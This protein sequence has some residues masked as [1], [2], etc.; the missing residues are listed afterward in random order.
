MQFPLVSI[1]IPSYNRAHLIGETLDSVLAQTYTNWEC[2]VVD[3]GSTD[4]TLEVLAGYCKKDARFQY[5][6]RPKNRTKG[7]NACRNYG[8]ELSKGKYIQLLDSDDILEVFCL[9]ERVNLILKEKS[10]NLLIRDT[11]NLID[12]Q[13]CIHSINK[14]PKFKTNEAYLRMF[15]SYDI[16]WQ[17]M[18]AFY[19]RDLFRTSHFDEALGRFQDV[20]FNIYVLSEFQDLKIKRDYKIDSYYR[21]DETKIHKNNFIKI[22]LNSLLLF[23]FIHKKLLKNRDYR[24]DLRKFNYK[25]A[26]EFVIPYFNQNKV[27]ANKVFINFLI[28][29][30]YNCNQKLYIFLLM[31]FLNIGIFNLRGIGMYRFMKKFKRVMNK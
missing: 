26:S 31:L 9:Y 15:L 1:I 13:K 18:G 11:S 28:I 21:V 6:N 30:I 29:K 20:S 12:N 8:F 3:D 5:H 22:V 19:K 10:I 2:I 23:N 4:H 17:T 25:I 7:A 16:P 14:D 27:D 24:L